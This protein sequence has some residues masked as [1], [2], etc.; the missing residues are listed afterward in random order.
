MRWG[1]FTIETHHNCGFLYWNIRTGCQPSIFENWH[2]WTDDRPS[3]CQLCIYVILK[4]STFISI[5][6]PLLTTQQLPVV[7]HV[8]EGIAQVCDLPDLIPEFNILPFIPEGWWA[9]YVLHNNHLDNGGGG[10]H[11]HTRPR[12]ICKVFSLHYSEPPTFSN[13]PQSI[14]AGH[15]ERPKVQDPADEL[16]WTTSPRHCSQVIP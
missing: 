13:I 6:S 8:S 11:D 2:N 4:L 5:I 1:E 15:E 16:I 12:P 3:T 9:M 14:F 7:D 10:I